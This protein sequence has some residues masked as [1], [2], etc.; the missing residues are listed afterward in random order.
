MSR[1]MVGFG[2]FFCQAEN[3]QADDFGTPAIRG[4]MPRNR[5]GRA[6][7]SGV[8]FTLIGAEGSAPD[9]VRLARRSIGRLRRS[10]HETNSGGLQVQPAPVP[11]NPGFAERGCSFYIIRLW[12]DDRRKR[13]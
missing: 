11:K 1:Y 4:G 10:H 13:E 6:P 7:I 12:G 5:V 3:Q 2:R 8:R 9:S